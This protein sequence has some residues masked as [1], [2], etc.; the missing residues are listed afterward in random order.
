LSRLRAIERDVSHVKSEFRPDIVHVNLAGANALFHLR[1]AASW[2]GR[3][4]VMLQA[5]LSA[6][7]ALSP[8]VRQLVASASHL[9]APSET[10][11]KHFADHLDQGRAVEA[12]FPGVK[13]LG[14]ER[15]P[16]SFTDHPR[17]IVALGRLVRDKGFDVAIRA[18]SLLRGHA[19]LTIIGEGPAEAELRVLVDQ[20]K[21]GGMVKLPGRLE[22]AD[23]R[24]E[25]S[26]ACAMVVP[27]R[28]IEFFGMVAAEAAL[29]GLPVVASRVGGLAEVVVDGDTGYTVPPDDPR[30]LASALLRLCDDPG[31]AMAMGERARDRARRLFTSER[32][33]ARFERLYQDSIVERDFSTDR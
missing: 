6:R 26:L 10:A 16:A 3:T 31:L 4:I 30:A 13:S 25:L 21:L 7:A 9:V 1:T 14:I 8:V 20:L 19:R 24:R 2:P 27:S 15:S 33:V 17:R 32:L 22:D 5:P 28:H 23:L 12:I 11:A 29:S 18:M